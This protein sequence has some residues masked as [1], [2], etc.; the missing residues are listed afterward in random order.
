MEHRARSVQ[1]ERRD[2]IV[3]TC[4]TSLNVSMKATLLDLPDG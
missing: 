3:K 1:Q 2:E 4:Q